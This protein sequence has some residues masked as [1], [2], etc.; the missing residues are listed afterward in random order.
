VPAANKAVN[1]WALASF[2]ATPGSRGLPDLAFGPVVARDLGKAYA[3]GPVELARQG[4]LAIGR[5]RAAVDAL[6]AMGLDQAAIDHQADLGA[7]EVASAEDR[8]PVL[9]Q[10]TLLDELR[11]TFGVDRVNAA[12]ADF[13]NSHPEPAGLFDLGDLPDDVVRNSGYACAL[14]GS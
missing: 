11:R 14:P 3:V 8:D 2:V 12:S 13:S 5:A 1:V 7:T 4:A 6:R 9:I 10:E